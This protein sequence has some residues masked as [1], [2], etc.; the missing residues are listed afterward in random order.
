MSFPNSEN[1]DS[2]IPFEL[3]LLI[4]YVGQASW[5]EKIGEFFSDFFCCVWLWFAS[6]CNQNGKPE[7]E[8]ESSD[9]ATTD[10]ESGHGEVES[11]CSQL[12]EKV[13]DVLSGRSM[14]SLGDR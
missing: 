12:E 13:E 11:S 4:R 5:C 8:I 2:T 10:L 3:R 6:M 1:L 7:D 9:N 14:P